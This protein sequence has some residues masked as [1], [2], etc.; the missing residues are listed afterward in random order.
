MTY[1][2]K[3]KFKLL[4]FLLAI[5]ILSGNDSFSNRRIPYKLNDK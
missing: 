1:R 3:T 2:D 5:T 4:A